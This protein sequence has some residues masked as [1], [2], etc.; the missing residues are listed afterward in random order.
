[1]NIYLIGM[2]GSGKSRTGRKLAARLRWPMLDLD[3][4][5]EERTGQTVDE[6]F[7]L[8]GESYF[9]GLETEAMNDLMRLNNMVIATGGGT[10]CYGNLLNEMVDTGI[11][12]YLKSS[13]KVLANR[14]ANDKR[15]RPLL[16]D[17]SKDAVED[18][19]RE[20]LDQ[21]KGIYERAAHQVNAEGS[22]E[23]IVQEIVNLVGALQS[24]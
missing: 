8:H 7:E 9:R 20:L 6:L 14:L 23:Q 15:V 4:V 11:T 17:L 3:E 19:L 18:A 22:S 2:M 21:R 1:M 24:K 13:P 16:A 5:I 10:P 12:I